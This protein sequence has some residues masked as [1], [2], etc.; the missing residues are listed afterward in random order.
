MNS[1]FEI[2]LRKKLI[3]I[4]IPLDAINNASAKEKSIRHGHPNT[5]H[6]WWA[7]RPLAASRAVIFCQFIDDPSSVP[8]EFKTLDEQANERERLFSLIA[9]MVKW[10]NNKNQKLYDQLKGEILKSWRRCCEDNKNHPESSNL[11]NP[12]KLPEFYDPFGGGG[13]I[14]CE[15]SRLGFKSYSSDLNPIP[16]IINKSMINFPA[17]FRNLSPV[18]LKNNNQNNLFDKSWKGLSG[19]AEDV[20]FYGKYLSEKAKEKVSFLYPK[21]FIDDEIVQF[22]PDLKDYIGQNLNVI[23]WIW[24]RTV[25]SPDPSFSNVY[26][27]LISTYILSKSKGKEAY[28]EPI[29][30]GNNYKFLVK[31]GKPKNE[32]TTKTGTKISRANFRCLLSG[33]TISNEYIKTEGKAGRLKS[34]LIAIV[35]D[36]KNKRIYLPATNSHEEIANN[37]EIADR[38]IIKISGSTQY[39]GVRPYGLDTFDKIYTN[40]QLKVLSILTELIEVV[41]DKIKKDALL[42]GLSKKDTSINEDEISAN[43]YA[44]AVSTYL[45]FTI[46]KG[47]DYWTNLCTWHNGRDSISHTFGRQAIPITWDYAEANPFSGS[48]GS[49]DSALKFTSNALEQLPI[50]EIGYS[51]QKNAMTQDIGINKIISTDPP[52]YDN[53]PY[54]DLSDLFYIWLRKSLKNIFPDNFKTI[55]VP[56]KEELVAFAHL[57]ENKNLAE[58]FFLDG[59]KETIK[60][61]AAQKH[62]AYSLTIFYAFKQTET[63][64]DG[65]IAST[66]WETFLEAVISSGLSISATWPMKTEYTN[67]LKSKRNVLASSIVLACDKKSDSAEI[68]TRKDF[69]RKLKNELPSALDALEKANISAVDL[70]QAAIGP[71]MKIY[72]GYKSVLNPDDTVMS[73]RDVLI[74][75]NYALDEHLSSFLGDIDADTRFAIS[76]FESFGFAERSYGDAEGLA[77]AKNVSV[78]GIV[79]SGILSSIG[80]KVKLKQ[81][82]ELDLNWDPLTD[83]RLSIWEAIHYLIKSI[84][85]DGEIVAADLLSKLKKINNFD[86]IS[87]KCKSVAYHLYNYC[88]KNKLSDEGL[89]YNN[90]IITLPELEKINTEKNIKTT[91]QTKLI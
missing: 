62:P 45:A 32:L 49:W 6:L 73:I 90:L 35:A 84:E 36:G 86:D 71:A 3:D 4:S 22:R 76:F 29:I 79:D 27:P 31:N 21:I 82:K 58:K 19:I 43:N 8:E 77:K 47:A 12:N 30:E 7:R 72:S 25:K 5:L 66:G 46:D 67:T 56:K 51:Y 65:G 9:E 1:N 53:I 11:F 57:H 70:A 34:K 13:S 83:N 26:V 74:E 37:I 28:L 60:R 69:K 44:E 88:E 81:I 23:S 91:I 55:S 16:V 40:R 39:V 85:N 48:T 38:P 17:K 63:K 87:E 14:P 20:R 41:K 89:S 33:S 68:I 59:M 61:L 75:I 15:A 18:N 80:G 78:N 24:A 2:K 54:A 64:S 10:E 42:S 50:S 52:Y